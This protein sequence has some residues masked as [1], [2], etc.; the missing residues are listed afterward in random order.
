MAIPPPRTGSA[1]LITGASSGIGAAIAIELSRR[2]HD[3]VLVARRVDRL[4][5]LADELRRHGRRVEVIPCDVADRDARH[6]FLARL[7]D[8]GLEI[9]VAVLSAGFGMGGPFVDADPDKVVQMIRT[10]VESTIILT[11]AVL[12]GMLERRRGALLLV[13]SMAGHQPMPLFGTYAA[14]KAA[15]T[16]F[17]EMLSAEV[18]SHGVTVTALCPGIVRTEFS[19]VGGVQETENKM[20]G[21]IAMDADECARA[22]VQGLVDGRRIVMPKLAVRAMVFAGTRLPRSIWLPL[23]RRLMTP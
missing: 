3:T 11:H 20:P 12:G 19:A 18:A 8:L 17:A 21:V 15:I 22:A 16:S 9:D 1:A 4:D 7:A 10:N 23:C 13:S 2:G 5:E 14:T 6:Q